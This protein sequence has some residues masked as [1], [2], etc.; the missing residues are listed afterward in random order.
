[1]LRRASRRA[2]TLIELLVVIAIIAVLIALLLPAVQAAREAARRAQCTNN[3][4]QIGLAV[5]N[6]ESTHGSFPPGAKYIAHAT[7]YHF[8]LPYMEGSAL[9]NAYNFM[10]SNCSTPALTYSGVENT[11]VS[12][13]RVNSFSCPSD[14]NVAPLGGVTSG[15]YVCN[16]GSTGTGLFQSQ[17]TINGVVVPFRG[18]PFSWLNASPP[19]CPA[20]PTVRGASTSTISS[21]TDGTSNTLL[22]SETIQGQT[23]GSLTDLR[24]FIQYGSSCGFSAILPPNSPLPDDIN[25]ASYC[26][27]QRP[28]PPCQFRDAS[29]S[30]TNIKFIDPTGASTTTRTGDQ[31]AARSRHPGG[32]NAVNCDGSVKFYKNTVNPLTWQALASSQGGEIISSDSL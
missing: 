10:G 21:I 20:T 6:Y 30:L 26:A 3:L 1:M 4:K 29:P 18:A 16:F 23:F 19:T 27:N 22:A 13:A 7:W 5:M 11:T 9:S 12:Y 31:Y 25:Q 15:N 28:N 32:V 17:A 8:T 14:Q 2:F 24:G